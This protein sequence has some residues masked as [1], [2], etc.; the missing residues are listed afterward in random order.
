MILQQ[1][2]IISPIDNIDGV[3]DIKIENGV[4]AE[5]AQNIEGDGLDFSGMIISSGLVDMHCHLR[6][7]GLE[8]K[9]TIQ[10][11]IESAL[12][13]GFTAICPMANTSPVV[14]N[15][16]TLKYTIDTAKNIGFYPICAVTKGLQGQELTDFDALKNN[17]AIAF[18]DDG[19]PLENLEM[20]EKALKTGE[21]IISHA[22][23]LELLGNQLC[24]SVAV[25]KEL[26]ILGKVGGRLHFA[27][28]S[29]ARSIELIRQAKIEGLNVTCET[30]PHYFSFTKDDETEDGR[31]KMNPPLATQA[32]LTAVIE[33]L[34]DGTIDCIATDHAPHSL[35]EKTKPFAESPFGVVGFET[36]LGLSLKL[37]EDGHLTINQVIEKLSVNPAKIL[38]L[39]NHGQ[40]KI[41]EVAN[42]T[43][44]DPNIKYK[45]KAEEFKTKCKITPFEGIELK[46]KA[47]GVVV[48][49]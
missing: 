27:H 39:K 8:Y 6:E 36:A 26:E 2:K 22:E 38:G 5:I 42:L 16:E 28:I 32:D 37:V 35:E 31:F 41:G 7:P 40:V 12:N 33:G 14:D 10:T 3:F 18:S 13:G 29:T 9:E 30:A 43:I 4:I 11:G 44:I 23:N 49:G 24:E 19:R 47:I 21:L 1:A 15:V 46:G 48:K 25:A 17:G 20:L 45:I 34:K